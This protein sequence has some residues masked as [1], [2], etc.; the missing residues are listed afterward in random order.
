MPQLRR[1]RQ[2]QL[3]DEAPTVPTVVRLPYDPKVTNDRL[4]L[5]MKGTISEMEVA[6]FRE[7]AQA[8]LLQKAQRGAL[9]RRVAIGYVKGAD[10]RIEKDPDARIRSTIDLIFRKFAE[11]GS[12]QGAEAE[13]AGEDFYWDLG[14]CF[15][16][17]DLDGADCPVADQVSATES[18]VR[19]V[20]L[21]P[22]V[23]VTAATVCVPRPVDL[24]RQSFSTTA[25]GDA[26][27]GTIAFRARLELDSNLVERCHFSRICREIQS[28]ETVPT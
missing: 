17:P 9:V 23:P 7:R 20:A 22:C 13:P 15:A 5:G 27:V 12:A 24:D 10:D 28:K 2:R 4:L 11:L 18:D 8:A 19:L 21:E 26:R 6:T 16:N 1:K 25:V 14:E 3:F